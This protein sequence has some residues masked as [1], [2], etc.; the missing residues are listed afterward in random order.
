MIGK[1]ILI[2]IGGALGAM[3]REFIIITLP[4][5]SNGFPLNIFIANVLASFLMGFFTALF[6]YKIINQYLHIMV[7][8]G[9]L[10]GLSTFSTFI[11]G[12]WSMGMEN[13]TTVIIY[14]LAS[15]VMGFYA[16][17]AGNKYGG[18]F[19]PYKTL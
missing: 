16:M 15:L 17:L 19:R 10:G 6:K 14:L 9:V 5:L 7:T 12:I 11:F 18:I 4:Q 1:A 2:I 8:T 13:L 3:C